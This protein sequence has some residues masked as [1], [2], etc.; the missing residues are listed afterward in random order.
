MGTL[1]P[2]LPVAGLDGAVQALQTAFTMELVAATPERAVYHAWDRLLKRHVALH[3]HLMADEPGRAWFLRETETLAALDHPTIRHVYSAG[4]L[5]GFAYRTANWVEGESLAEALRRGPRPLPTAHALVRDLLGAAEHAHAR[6]VIIRRIV[7]ATLMLEA[8]E[9]A[10][11]T[12][13]RYSSWC[14]PNVPPQERGTGGAFV[15]PEVRAGGVGEPASDVYAVAALVYYVL[16]GQ[17]PD[18]DPGRIVPPRQ[19]RPAIPVVLERVLLRALQGAPGDRYFT[20]TE[21]LEDFVSDAGVFQQ[22]PATPPVAEAGFERRLRRALG[23]DYELLD[24]IGTGGFGRVYRARD[25]G[26]EREVAIKV[27]HPSLTADPT[28]MERFRREA[29][30][31][32]RARHPSI[33]NVYDI[34]SRAGLQWYTMELVPGASL[35]QLVQKQGPLSVDQTFRVL[36]QAL[37]ALE[38]AHG[39]GLV[40]RDLKPENMLIEPDGRLRITDFGLALALRGDSRFGG[41]TSRSG[42]PQFAAPEQLLGERVDQRA[43]LYSL[44]ATAYFA[45]LGRPPFEGPTPEAILA[46]QA[47]EDVPSLHDARRDVSRELEQVLRVALAAD[48]NARYPSAAA[49]RDALRRSRGLAYRLRNLLWGR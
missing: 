13:L 40:H 27:L 32:A 19:L 5:E 30:L 31:A 18:A 15:A 23:D 11:I 43:D 28:V 41:A 6:G 3:V 42:T 34:M 22:P 49:F 46:R 9:R 45:L 26:L 12:D 48:P 10:V 44:A 7:P 17:E 4:V 20:A 16:T 29:Q 14:L 8:S 38:H 39:L 25:L 2:P 36:N 33:V 24:E 37:S 35:A 1:G 47:T 21:M